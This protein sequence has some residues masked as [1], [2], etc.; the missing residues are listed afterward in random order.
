MINF[1]KLCVAL[2]ALRNMIL[3]LLFFQLMICD[4]KISMI[5]DRLPLIRNIHSVLFVEYT[6]KTLKYSEFG[7]I[8]LPV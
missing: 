5:V 2:C 1:I 7:Y 4:R 6:P 3:N 8:L